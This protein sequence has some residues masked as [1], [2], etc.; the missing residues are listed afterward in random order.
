MKAQFHDI[1]D[2]EDV[3]GVMFLSF[4]GDLVLKQ[5]NANMPAG[6]ADRDLTSLVS[7][8]DKIKEAELIYDNC[9]IYIIRARSGYILVVMGR[10]APIAMV[11]LNCGIILPSLDKTG[12][13][14]KG[15]A[16]LFRKQT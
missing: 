9:M 4:E 1:L 15:L 3:Q 7:T 12:K 16:R 6:L 2:V 13:K 10:F 14:P 5:F 11:R 8:L